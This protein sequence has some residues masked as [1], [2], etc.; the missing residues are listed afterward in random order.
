MDTKAVL[1]LNLVI[2]SWKSSYNVCCG[3]RKG[4]PNASERGFLE[5]DIIDLIYEDAGLFLVEDMIW[6]YRAFY[7]GR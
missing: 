5:G 6:E 2:I 7:T 3:S 4:S 1:A